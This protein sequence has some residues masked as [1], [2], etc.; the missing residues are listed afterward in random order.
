MKYMMNSRLKKCVKR[1]KRR[2]KN[3]LSFGTE[4]NSLKEKLKL[5]FKEEMNKDDID[6][7]NTELKYLNSFY[8]Y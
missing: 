6:Y 4:L 3:S 1:T 5:A 7:C 2:F 8:E